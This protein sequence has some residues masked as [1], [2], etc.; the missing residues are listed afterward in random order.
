MGSPRTDHFA[1]GG[2]LY[3]KLHVLVDVFIFDEGAFG[4]LQTVAF[5]RSR[6]KAIQDARIHCSREAVT[7][8]STTAMPLHCYN[9]ICTRHVGL[10]VPDTLRLLDSLVVALE[11]WSIDLQKGQGQYL[12][13]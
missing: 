3:T 4:C 2:C 9:A 12:P 1:A 5:G 8:A 13:A 11:S 10:G 7:M 6:N